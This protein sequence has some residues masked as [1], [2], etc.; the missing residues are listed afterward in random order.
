M[1]EVKTED[2]R[3]IAFHN[4]KLRPVNFNIIG[5]ISEVKRRNK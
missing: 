4:P 1:K 5:W 2:G 3:I